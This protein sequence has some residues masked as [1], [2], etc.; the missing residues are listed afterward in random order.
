MLIN[1]R[2]KEDYDAHTYERKLIFF[3]Q[4]RRKKYKDI[5]QLIRHKN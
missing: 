1:Y 3:W 5:W 4:K 2:A